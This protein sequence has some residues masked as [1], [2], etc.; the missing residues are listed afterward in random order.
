MVVAAS[1]LVLMS[2]NASQESYLSVIS[3]PQVKVMRLGQPVIVAPGATIYLQ[4]E[5]TVWA[6][7]ATHPARVQV[8]KVAFFALMPLSKLKFVGLD[9][10]KMP[11]F[12]LVSGQVF[13][14]EGHDPE[15]R[16]VSRRKRLIRVSQKTLGTQGTFF[17]VTLA[18]VLG[19]QSMSI[20]VFEGT[21]E[22]YH[23]QT[24]QLEHK[25]LPGQ[26]YTADPNVP[27]PKD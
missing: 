4:A 14:S 1:L 7:S 3:T 24:S 8:D 13:F 2:L 22:V 5:D 25:V 20:A 19:T 16:Q 12:E 15:P 21:V 11:E 17:S 10:D 23:R 27:I 9:D 6:T 18:E 26:V